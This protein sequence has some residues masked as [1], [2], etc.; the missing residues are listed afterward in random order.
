MRCIRVDVLVGVFNGETL[1]D[2][3]QVGYEANQTFGKNPFRGQ[4]VKKIEI[5]SLS[6]TVSA[7]IYFD[8]GIEYTEDVKRYF[9]EKSHKNTR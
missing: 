5:N 6:Y 1:Y 9:N 2:V 8:N 7:I 3:Y 4:K